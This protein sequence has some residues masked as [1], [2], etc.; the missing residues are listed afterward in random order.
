[1]MRPR[2]KDIVPQ[3][4][5]KCMGFFPN[6]P[7]NMMEP[8]SRKPLTKRSQPNLVTPYFRARCSTTFSPILL[9]TAHITRIV[10]YLYISPYISM[11]FTTFLLYDFKPQLKSWSLIFELLLAAA[12]NNLEG[13]FFVNVLS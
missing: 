4:P 6:F 9:I 3:R 1:M 5:K 7:T 10:M 11:L 8:R 2:R 13:I 12:L